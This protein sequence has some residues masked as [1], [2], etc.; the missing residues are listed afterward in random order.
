MTPLLASV[1]TYAA[2]S[3]HGRHASTLRVWEIGVNAPQHC[4]TGDLIRNERVAS[5]TLVEPDPL[6]AQSLRV[7]FPGARVIECAIVDECRPATLYRF[8]QSTYA[9]CVGIMAPAFAN[10]AYLR[11][12]E[13]ERF[14]ANGLTLDIVDTGCIDV[15]FLDTEGCEWYALK[16]MRSRPVV[17]AVEM[18]WGEYVN[19]HRAE[20][21]AWLIGAGYSYRETIEAD[22]IYTR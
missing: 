12:D 5:V 9:E 6:H 18:Q 16:H 15:L 22:H 21:A 1:M 8:D 7:E 13:A 10:H 19:P 4:T 14:V 17:I 3:P 11:P 20:I 2:E